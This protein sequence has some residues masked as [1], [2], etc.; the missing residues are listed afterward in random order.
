VYRK[1]LRSV[2]S[3]GG[4]HSPRNEISANAPPNVVGLYIG[5]IITAMPIRRRKAGTIVPVHPYRYE[6]PKRA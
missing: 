1:I 2:Q 4:Q 3:A 5:A 6:L